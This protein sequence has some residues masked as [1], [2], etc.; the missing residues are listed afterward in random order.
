MFKF[1]WPFRKNDPETCKAAAI[2]NLPQF[3]SLEG[4]IMHVLASDDAYIFGRTVHQIQ[5]EV[6]GQRGKYIPR[7]SISPRMVSLE[8]KGFIKRVGRAR[9]QKTKQPCIVWALSNSNAAKRF[10]EL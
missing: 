1:V 5:S 3:K 7:D 6:S 9:D 10:S 4:T 2:K 8:R